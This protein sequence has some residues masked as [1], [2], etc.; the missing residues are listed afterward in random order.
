MDKYVFGYFQTMDWA[1]K[2]AE[3]LKQAGFEVSLDDFSPIGGTNPYDT[4]DSDS[5][6]PFQAPEMS[7]AEST[8]G[9]PV[10][11]QDSR[12][13][14]STHPDASGFSGSEPLSAPE[15]INLTV[16]FSHEKE[17]AQIRQILKKYGARE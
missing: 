15:N 2:A 16:F 14:R 13:L 3:E 11:R 9:D 8:L 5:K 4:E 12:I 10:I 17:R 7:L 1:K 6:N